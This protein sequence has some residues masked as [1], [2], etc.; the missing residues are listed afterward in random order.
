MRTV[1]IHEPGGAE[2][3]KVEDLDVPEPR[4]GEVRVRVHVLYGQASGP[5]KPIDPQELNRLGSLFLTRPTLFHYVSTRDELE[6]RARDLFE[7]I[8]QGAVRVRI[9]RTF[10]L[11]DAA[12]AH[13]YLEGRQT[14][15]KV[16]LT[17]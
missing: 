15:G 3:L 9:D 1:R 14:R 6:R 16:L 4:S 11:E 7:W 2:V 13:R 8:M 10:P 17:P 12:E 5:V